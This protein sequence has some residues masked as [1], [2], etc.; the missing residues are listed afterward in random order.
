MNNL[1]I[2]ANIFINE[3]NFNNIANSL[4]DCINSI[5]NEEKKEK[6]LKRA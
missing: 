2:K 4:K 1:R 3:F 6:S 5:Q